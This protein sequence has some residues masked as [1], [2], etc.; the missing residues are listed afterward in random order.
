MILLSGAPLSLFYL[1]GSEFDFSQQEELPFV[2]L[3]TQI[4]TRKEKFYS[5]VLFY[6]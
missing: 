3:A 4:P 5:V 1:D 2:N 6:L